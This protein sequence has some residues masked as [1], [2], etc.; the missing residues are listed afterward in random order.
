MYLFPKQLHT[1]MLMCVCRRRFW[2]NLYQRWC[3]RIYYR[4]RPRW[5]NSSGRSR[6]GLIAVISLCLTAFGL[7]ICGGVLFFVLYA[8]VFICYCKL[9]KHSDGEQPTSRIYGIIL[10]FQKNEQKIKMKKRKT[11]CGVRLFLIKYPYG[12][13]P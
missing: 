2:V 8:K 1:L 7:G 10:I 4:I 11:D 12:V 9:G 13:L 6:E 5:K 3:S